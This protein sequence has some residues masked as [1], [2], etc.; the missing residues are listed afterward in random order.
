[1][2]PTQLSC[3]NNIVKSSLLSVGILASRLLLMKKNKSGILPTCH[4]I[5]FL[6]FIKLTAFFPF[7]LNCQRL[8]FFS[9]LDM[10]LSQLQGETVLM[11]CV[12]IFLRLSKN[13]YVEFATDLIVRDFSI[14]MLI[15]AT[16]YSPHTIKLV[17]IVTLVRHIH[18]FFSF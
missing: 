3:T 16:L 18:F 2:V 10:Y 11:P 17:I 6:V 5:S 1:M 15:L 13:T 7:V 12:C 9:S 8:S 4:G 14:L